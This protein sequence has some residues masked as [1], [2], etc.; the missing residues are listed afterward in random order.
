VKEISERA[1]ASIEEKIEEMGKLVEE[2]VLPILEAVKD[3]RSVRDE[4][5][6]IARLVRALGLRVEH[7]EARIA[8]V[9]E[10]IKRLRFLVVG[11]QGVGPVER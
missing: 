4:L 6:H 3:L 2:K 11:G 7:L 10:E 8:G 1:P 9:E 5:S